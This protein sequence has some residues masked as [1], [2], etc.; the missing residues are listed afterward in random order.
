[1]K[2]T[3]KHAQ[4]K[5]LKYFGVFILLIGLTSVSLQSAA[6]VT[7][8]AKIT[9]QKDYKNSIKINLTSFILYSTGIQLNYERLLSSK[10]SITVFGGYIQFPMPT[11]IANSP[12]NFDKNKTKNGYS[13]GSEYRFYL[14]SENKYAA[15][16][17][18]YLA[19]FISYYHFNNTRTGR[20]TTNPDNQLTLNTTLSF[21]NIGGELG[22]QFVIKNRFV[23]DCVLFG[24]AISSYYFS[25]KMSGSSGDY[26]EH[27][28][29]VLDALKEK[30][31][32]LKDLSNGVKVSTSGVSNF[33][34]LGFRYGINIG[35]RF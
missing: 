1:M 16:H 9:F 25:L 17:G 13:I 7:D 11:V 12:L 8:S 3:I 26:N 14:T 20:D 15:P 10:R 27:L 35:Y 18:V 6:Q 29:E 28:Q 4:P 2:F 24:P 21:L 5:L 33:W 19:P 30:Y 23:I 22:Y 32:L 34:S 31:P